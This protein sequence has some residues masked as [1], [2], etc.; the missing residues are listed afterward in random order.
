MKSTAV[1]LM[2]ALLF[3]SCSKNE[4]PSEADMPL[5]AEEAVGSIRK[6]VHRISGMSLQKLTFGKPEP[7]SIVEDVYLDG[8]GRVRR[9]VNRGGCSPA[10]FRWNKRIEYFGESGDIICLLFVSYDVPLLGSRGSVFFH[11]GKPV[12]I[13]AFSAGGDAVRRLNAPPGGYNRTSADIVKRLG[14]DGERA[15]KG[16]RVVLGPP[17]KND[18]TIINTNDVVIRSAPSRTGRRLNVYSDDGVRPQSLNYSVGAHVFSTA[19]V[20]SVGPEE[21]IEPWGSHR[22]CRVTVETPFAASVTGW[23]FG[24]FLEPVERW[25]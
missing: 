9:L 2:L 11:G 20:L 23:L 1:F 25:W 18:V 5:T 21:T 22:W 3:I 19:K 17:G 13:S 14:I 6:E 4:G 8:K 12:R 16:K 7:G 15:R 10:A 24:G